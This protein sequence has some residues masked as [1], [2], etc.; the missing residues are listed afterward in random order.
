MRSGAT[1]RGAGPDCL[2][3]ECEK[4]RVAQPG[5]CLLCVSAQDDLRRF[6]YQQ[7]R[8]CRLAVHG[9][10]LVA[11]IS[12]LPA[13]AGPLAS[14]P[15]GWPREERWKSA[16]EMATYSSLERQLRQIRVADL[17]IFECRLRLVVFNEIVLDSPFAGLREDA[18]PVDFALADVRHVAGL[19]GPSSPAAVVAAP[20]S[21][22]GPVLSMHEWESAG[23]AVKILHRI[24]PAHSN[25]A[26][27][28]FHL[29]E[30]VVGFREEEVVRQVAAQRFGRL[31]LK[32]VIV[33]SEL[34]ARLL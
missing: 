4:R 13:G 31:E 19:L 24:L 33:I 12:R 6:V 1:Q 9:Q 30:L 11:R 23:V 21:L 10:H 34:D 22:H 20:R 15:K 25:P 17:D 5:R 7:N 16:A 26:E 32:R 14:A 8:H 18:L 28:H 27:V 29:Y 3:Q 2:S